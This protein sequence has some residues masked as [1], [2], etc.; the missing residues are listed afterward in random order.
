MVKTQREVYAAMH[1]AGVLVNLHYIPVYRQP[2]YED[3]GNTAECPEAD[4]YYAEA[5]TIPLYPAMSEAQQD[6]VV[7]ALRDAVAD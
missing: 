5:L 2:Y 7:A 3:I 4:K 1:E 6:S